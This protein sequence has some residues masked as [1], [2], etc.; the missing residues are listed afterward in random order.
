MLGNFSPEIVLSLLFYDSR[1]VPA[2]N[3]VLL[4]S[5]NNFIQK[6]VA[7]RAHETVCD[8]VS[9]VVIGNSLPV[10]EARC[11]LAYSSNYHTIGPKNNGETLVAVHRVPVIWSINVKMGGWWVVAG[12]L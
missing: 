12:L 6:L 3:L 7:H 5:E 4:V 11:F 8:G 9:R 2:L 1:L 10:V